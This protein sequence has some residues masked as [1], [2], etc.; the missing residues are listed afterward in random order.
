MRRTVSIR[1]ANG[2]NGPWVGDGEA[3]ATQGGK[4]YGGGN[5]TSA[6]GDTAAEGIASTAL[7]ALHR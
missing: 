7:A 3:L 1:G 5:F 2:A 4:L 6:G